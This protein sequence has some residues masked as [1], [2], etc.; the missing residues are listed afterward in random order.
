MVRGRWQT[1]VREI[2]RGYLQR[3]SLW[4]EGTPYQPEGCEHHANI[5]N[6]QLC[7]VRLLHKYKNQPQKQRILCLASGKK[8]TADV[9]FF[10]EPL[11][12]N[13]LS[14]TVGNMCSNTGI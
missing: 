8:T 2:G 9:W 1:I 11:G 12:H 14:Q 6:P 5:N 10:R 3:P 4:V 7:F 13:K